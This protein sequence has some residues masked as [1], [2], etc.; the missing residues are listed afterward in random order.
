MYGSKAA[1]GLSQFHS[2][3]EGSP[4][5][6][7][8][9]WPTSVGAVMPDQVHARF[10]QHVATSHPGQAEPPNMTILKFLS[11]SRPAGVA[12]TFSA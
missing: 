1:G 6:S 12:S 11:S 5:A 3:S 7:S 10:D 9:S 4:E 8:I 2:L